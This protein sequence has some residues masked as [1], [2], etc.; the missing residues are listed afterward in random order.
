MLPG[1]RQSSLSTRR[2][3]R[4]KPRK[5]RGD[6]QDRVNADVA[7]RA[8]LAQARCLARAGRREEA[9]DLYAKTLAGKRFARPP[10]SMTG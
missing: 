9:I 7:A 1:P 2:R 5:L 3:G 10:T 8:I 4:A 6:R